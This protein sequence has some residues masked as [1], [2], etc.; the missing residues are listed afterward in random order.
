MNTL[1]NFDEFLNELNI[2]TYDK[3]K[4]YGHERNDP[5]GKRLATLAGERKNKV[6]GNNIK[7][8]LEGS[9]EVYDV[10]LQ[11]GIVM[12]ALPTD[13]DRYIK[14]NIQNHLDFANSSRIR[15][16]SVGDVGRP[17]CSMDI[18]DVNNFPKK[19]Y[20]DRKGSRWIASEM[21]RLLGKEIRS[22]QLP[23]F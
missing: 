12:A 7:V 19:C 15:F 14:F 20:I 5:R 16:I 17:G 22:T 1:K 3:L 21:S 11:P 9:D 6:Y 2:E 8:K 10:L 4:K 13:K 18:Y 23:Q